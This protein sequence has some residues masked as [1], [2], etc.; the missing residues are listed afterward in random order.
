MAKTIAVVADTG[1]GKSTAL[2]PIKEIGH[3]GLNPKETLI[4]NVKNKPLPFKGWKKH[5]LPIRSK[6]DLKKGNY[7]ASSDYGVIIDT[8]NYFDQNRKEI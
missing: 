3:V 4:I 7:L 1:F 2:A 5:Y 6:E 8:I